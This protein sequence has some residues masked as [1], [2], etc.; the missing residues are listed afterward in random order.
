MKPAPGKVRIIGGQWR[1]T[2]LDVPEVRGLRPTSDRARET[3][4]NWLQPML[5]GARVLDLFAGTGALGLEA[6]SRGAAHALLVERDPVLAT[7]LAATASRLPGGAAVEVRRADALQVLATAPS[8]PF[9]LAFVDPPFD[10]GLWPAVLAA[11]PRALAA[12]AWL[13]V[14]SR[15]GQPALPGPDWQPH[16]ELCMRES[17]NALYRRVG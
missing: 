3:L 11:L 6:V 7:A 2:R 13:Y 17:H 9:D 4:F 15:A 14:E 1:G 5:P 16:R 12:D 10:D 8:A